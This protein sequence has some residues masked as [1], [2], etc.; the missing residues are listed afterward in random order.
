M[1]FIRLFSMFF[2]DEDCY[3]L[4]DISEVRDGFQTDIF[5]KV[6]NNPEVLSK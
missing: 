1:A 5:N 4:R 6:Q 2:L 3:S